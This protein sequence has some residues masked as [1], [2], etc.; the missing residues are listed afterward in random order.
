MYFIQRGLVQVTQFV[1]YRE[2]PICQIGDGGHFG[3]IALLRADQRRTASVVTLAFCELQVLSRKRFEKI[4]R[5]HREFAALV[6]RKGS[7]RLEAPEPI[8]RKP[9]PQRRKSKTAKAM[10]RQMT[11][12]KLS[13]ERK[14][15]A[16]KRR[17]KTGEA[18]SGWTDEAAGAAAMRKTAAEVFADA[19][20]CVSRCKGAVGKLEKNSSRGSSGK[21]SGNLSSFLGL[22]SAMMSTK[23]LGKGW[24][25]SS[26]RDASSSR[27]NCTDSTGRDAGEGQAAAAEAAPPLAGLA[28]Q[29]AGASHARVAPEA[30][31]V[32]Q[33]PDGL[34]GPELGVLPTVPASD[35]NSSGCMSVSSSGTDPR[36]GAP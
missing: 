14:T 20:S 27:G 8:A 15:G 12:T 22:T 4:Q 7:E 1:R 36:S 28:W 24:Y 35:R 11:L 26:R 23:R 5:D 16:S 13:V 9:T 17:R 18:G 21:G 29:R 2:N 19:Q 10:A 33:Q 34:P 31:S 32:Q 25:L 30:A 6:H 3:E